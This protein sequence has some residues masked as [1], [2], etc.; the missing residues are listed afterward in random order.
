MCRAYSWEISRQA[1]E[2][3]DAAAQ[4]AL[5]F[6]YERGQGVTRDEAEAVRWYHKAAEQGDATAKEGLARLGG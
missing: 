3:G 2:Q 4:V 1:A 5:G 6:R